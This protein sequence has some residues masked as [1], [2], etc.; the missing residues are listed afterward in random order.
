MP[1]MSE[2]WIAGYR[3]DSR[4]QN[5]MIDFIAPEV[6]EIIIEFERKNHE[7]LT[8]RERAIFQFGYVYGEKNIL[9]EYIDPRKPE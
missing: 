8:P 2:T 1:E 5:N 9:R 3:T 6:K 7:Y 4:K